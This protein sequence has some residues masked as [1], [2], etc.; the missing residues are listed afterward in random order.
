MDKPCT[1]HDALEFPD[2]QFV[3]LRHLLEGQRA[4]VLQLPAQA[5]KKTEAEHPLL[6]EAR[7][8]LDRLHDPQAGFHGRT[9]RQR[10]RSSNNLPAG[11]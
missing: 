7:C 3:L 10:T 6:P 9:S 4:V 11:S 5:K 1:H 2:G 8:A